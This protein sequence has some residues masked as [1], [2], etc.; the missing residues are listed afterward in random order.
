MTVSPLRQR[1]LS[2]AT[3]RRPR[4]GIIGFDGANAVDLTGPLETLTAAR[5][6]REG[7]DAARCYETMLIALNTKTFVTACGAMIK[8]DATLEKAPRLDTLVIPGGPGSR[9]RPT[10][11]KLSDWLRTHVS[12]LRRVAAVSTGVYAIA[13]SGLLTGRNVTT[14][15]RF[16]GELAQQFPDLRVNNRVTFVKDGPYLTSGG[17]TAGIEMTLSMIEEDCGPATAL[18]VARELVLDLKPPGT[19]TEPGDRFDYQLGPTERLA[20]LPAWIVAHLREDLSVERLA[21]RACIC[22]RHFS[23]LF[24][25]FFNTTP[26]QFVEELRLTEARRRLLQSRYS[27]EAVACAVGFKS[28]DSFRRAFER[29]FRLSPTAFRRNGTRTA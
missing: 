29:R 8:A 6:P 15:W 2:A 9:L 24:R 25:T 4:I 28:S 26:A 19:T 21:Q 20:D 11:D 23:R 18:D 14:H 12:E 1:S 10:A 16:A 17:G 7:Q 27:I 3:L 5:I 22:A 13:P